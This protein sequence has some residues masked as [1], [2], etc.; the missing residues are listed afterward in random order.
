MPFLTVWNAPT[1]NCLSQFDIDLDLGIFNIVQN[2][3]QVFLGDNITIFYADK[4]GLY[5]RYN[6]N[7]GTP[8]NGGVPQNSSLDKHLRAASDDIR[9]AIPRSDFQ[10][11]AVVDWE[12]WRPVWER[13]WDAKQVYWKGSRAVVRAEHPDWS[14]EQVETAARIE[15][16]K[17]AQKFME[18]TLRLGHRERPDG[19]WGF[20]GFPNCYNYFKGSNYT[21]E[22]PEVDRKRNDELFW[23]WNASSALYPDIYLS[24]PLQDMDKEVYLYSH[25]RILEAMRVAAQAT[26]Q[27]PAVFPYARIVYTYSFKFLSKDHLVFTIG[28]SAALGA[29]G[30]VLW[31]EHLFSKSKAQCEDIK[32]YIDE[33][34]G[35]YLVNVTSAAAL[36]S[37]TLC[38]S[39]GRCSRRSPS[40]GV[41]LHLDPEA[42]KIQSYK[43]PTGR[44]R[45]YKVLGQLRSREVALMKGK[46]RCN[47]YAGWRGARCAKRT[48]D[49]SL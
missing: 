37:Q 19:L 10:G 47:C 3:N 40:S 2:Q 28:E 7:E 20:Y 9:V 17:S 48:K 24:L 42:W 44:G 30:V 26:P 21:G 14:P 43:R 15:F 46:F 25:H 22:C 23:L 5:P 38:S 35:P 18:E 12:S 31:G 49:S 29:A 33:T 41:F 13:N 45:D 34:L 1:S 16:E 36:C 39:R 27:A 4:L 11:L 8:V 6:G 32:S